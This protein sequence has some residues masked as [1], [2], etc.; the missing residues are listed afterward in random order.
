M[1]LITDI[2]NAE[3]GRYSWGSRDCLTTARALIEARTGERPRIGAWHKLTEGRAVARAIK[4]Y[5][6]LAAAHRRF[7]PKTVE[8]LSADT[9]LQPG[10]IVALSR[11]TEIGRVSFR[12][13]ERLDYLGFVAD[14]GEIYT[15]S[16]RGLLPCA[17][18]IAAVYR[19]RR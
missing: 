11:L 16:P 2:L 18:E 19:C 7:L 9:P 5:G 15:W 14:S 17:G 12:S 1:S 3:Q 8:A 13:D 4:R 6:S 10:D